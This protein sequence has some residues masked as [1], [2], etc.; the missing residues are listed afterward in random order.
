MDS[1]DVANSQAKVK[2]PVPSGS[3]HA[4]TVLNRVDEDAL[5][6]APRDAERILD[7]HLRCD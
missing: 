1:A 6:V 7:A 2:L 4:P 5:A 3:D